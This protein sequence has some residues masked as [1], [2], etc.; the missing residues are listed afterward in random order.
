M[1]MIKDG[2]KNWT[3]I[4]ITSKGVEIARE[5]AEF[6]KYIN[7]EDANIADGEYGK[8]IIEAIEKVYQ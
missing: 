6:V 5:I 4:H 1:E 8:T 7:G 2:E 3:Q